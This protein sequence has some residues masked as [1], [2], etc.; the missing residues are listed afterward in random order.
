VSVE[1]T[2]QIAGLAD[3]GTAGLEAYQ[4]VNKIHAVANPRPLE[5]FCWPAECSNQLSYGRRKEEP[6]NFAGEKAAVKALSRQNWRPWEGG[7]AG[8]GTYGR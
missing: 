2:D 7:V 4:D 6:A 3:V 8:R 5:S 1:A